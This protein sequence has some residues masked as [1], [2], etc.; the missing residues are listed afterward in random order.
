MSNVWDGVERRGTESNLLLMLEER[1]TKQDQMLHDLYD[2]IKTHIKDEADLTPVVIELV[3]A[4]KA[5][6]FFVNIIKWLGIIAS[7]ISAT[8]FLIKGNKS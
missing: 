2:M 8:F 6:G 3:D 4:W 7:A 1:L 5:A